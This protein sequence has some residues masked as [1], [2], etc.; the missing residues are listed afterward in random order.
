MQQDHQHA[1]QRQRD[2]AGLGRRQADPEQDQRP[3]RDEQRSGR[4]QQQR[5][6]RLGMFEC[7][8]LQGVEGADTGDGEHDHGAEAG[9]DCAPVALEMFPGERENNEK[10]NRPAQERQRHR[11]DMAGGEAADDGVAGPAQRGDGEQQIGLVGEPA[12]RGGGFRAAIGSRHRA[13]VLGP[14]S[15]TPRPARYSTPGRNSCPACFTDT[16][17]YRAARREMHR[18]HASGDC[19]T[20]HQRASA[21][22]IRRGG[23]DSQPNGASQAALVSIC[24]TL[25]AG[26]PLIAIRRGFI[27]SGISRTSSICSKPL[28]NA[29][30]LTWT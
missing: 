6:Q 15:M 13:V 24:W 9:A 7:P 18:V 27:A 21:A 3:H 17:F 23:L 2:P 26:E 10:R 28:S 4:L 30:P 1:R 11:R 29:A 12:A 5:I 8:V 20:R 19:G 25:D 22:R 16:D 14:G